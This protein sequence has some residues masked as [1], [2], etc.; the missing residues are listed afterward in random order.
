MESCTACYKR[1]GTR[2]LCK[3]EPLPLEEVDFGLMDG[4]EYTMAE[5]MAY[6]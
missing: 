3:S 2:R 4:F 5:W 1:C 6:L